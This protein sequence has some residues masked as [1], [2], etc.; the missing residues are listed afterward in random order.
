MNR[1]DIK[2]VLDRLI[3]VNTDE[4]ETIDAAVAL[5]E[6]MWN[7]VDELTREQDDA[8]ADR[9]YEI[10]WREALRRIDEL[11]DVLCAGN[12]LDKCPECGGP[13]DNGH[14][15]CYPPEPYYCTKCMEAMK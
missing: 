11:E 3:A 8:L 13:A 6:Q 1:G 12:S 15:R 4:G 7:R 10:R 9:T 14:D 5:I 2:L